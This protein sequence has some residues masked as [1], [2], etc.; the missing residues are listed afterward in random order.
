MHLVRRETVKGGIVK[1]GV[2]YKK[3]S[4]LDKI[5]RIA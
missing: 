4:L 5:Y 2:V 3:C 1:R